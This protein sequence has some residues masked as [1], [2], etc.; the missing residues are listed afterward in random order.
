MFATL[1]RF[2]L[3]HRSAGLLFIAA[4]VGIA[5]LPLPSLRVDFSSAAFYGGDPE[6]EAALTRFQEHWGPDDDLLLVLLRPPEDQADKAPG[7]WALQP[8]IRDRTRQIERALAQLPGVRHVLSLASAPFPL[9]EFT[10]GLHESTSFR[11]ALEAQ[12]GTLRT[13]LS[14]DARLTAIAVELKASSDDLEALLPHVDAIE[15]E[16]E[17]QRSTH[18]LRID[19]AGLPRCATLFSSRPYGTK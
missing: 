17:R 18:A 10:N 13:I 19:L 9:S 12:R 2:L 7:G 4:L 3:A 15:A 1:A 16:L 8:E 6:R 14:D 11:E 5:L